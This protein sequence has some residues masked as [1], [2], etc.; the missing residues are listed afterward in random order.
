MIIPKPS[1]PQCPKKSDFSTNIPHKETI[2][3]QFSLIMTK[4]NFLEN[5]NENLLMIKNA[6]TPSKEKKVDR[7]QTFEFKKS[8]TEKI[9]Y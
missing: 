3:D 8:K 2:N 6:F 7:I 5:K 4:K 9:K 1:G